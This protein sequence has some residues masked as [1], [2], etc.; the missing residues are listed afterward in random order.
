ML[1]LLRAILQQGLEAGIL[2]NGVPASTSRIKS[3]LITPGPEKG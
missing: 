1:H 3:A 2:A